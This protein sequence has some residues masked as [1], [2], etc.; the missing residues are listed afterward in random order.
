MVGG[1]AEWV[2]PVA[3]QVQDTL[4]EAHGGPHRTTLGILVRGPPKSAPK[5][6]TWH[7]GGAPERAGS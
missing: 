7:P 2:T 1:A 6:Y 4:D 3:Q 5:N